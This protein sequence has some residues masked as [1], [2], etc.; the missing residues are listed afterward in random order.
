MRDL[1]AIARTLNA[2]ASVISAKQRA[3]PPGQE[4][5]VTVRDDGTWHST[6]R[7]GAD[8]STAAHEA[9]LTREGVRGVTLWYARDLAAT[10]KSV[11]AETAA[12]V[13]HERALPTCVGCGCADDAA[14]IGGCW[15]AAPGLCSRCARQAADVA[16]MSS[17]VGVVL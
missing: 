2:R 17:P 5:G 14:C 6:T 9:L 15:W 7:L 3:L 1:D 11:T 16:D 4:V 13:A 10:W 12:W 8:E